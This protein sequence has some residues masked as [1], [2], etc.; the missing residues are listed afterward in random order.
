MLYIINLDSDVERMSD[1]A[2]RLDELSIEFERV[3]AFDG[4][5]K[6]SAELDHYFH[7]NH[8]IHL[9]PNQGGAQVGC[10]LSHFS[11]WEKIAYG[12]DE[13]ALVFEDDVHF[14]PEIKKFIESDAWLPSD[15]DIIRLE[16]STNRLLLSKDKATEFGDRKISQLNSTSWCAGAYVL[17]KA[18]ANKLI[19]FK[20][21][22]FISADA[23]LF[24]LE[25]SKIANQ[26]NIYQVTPALAIQDKYTTE[27]VG[28]ES[29]I[30]NFNL[31]DGFKWKIT[32]V[33]NFLSIK[34]AAIKLIKGYE[35]VGFK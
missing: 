10:F 23:F 12:Q 9:S 15:F 11:V 24:C 4:R 17:S 22:K 27:K 19:S 13:F 29:N 21:E 6:T 14:S 30:E 2:R 34:N 16:V 1:M 35:R 32:N 18:C 28:Y 3:S 31:I 25:I 33:I 20:L 7:Q 26:L 5:N 8:K